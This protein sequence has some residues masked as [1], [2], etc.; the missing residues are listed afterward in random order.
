MMRII[1]PFYALLP[2]THG[3]IPQIYLQTS[4]STSIVPELANR[5]ATRPVSHP[6]LCVPTLNCSTYVGHTAVRKNSTVIGR[7]PRHVMKP[8]WAT[9]LVLVMVCIVAIL[10]RAGQIMSHATLLP[11]IGYKFCASYWS[12]GTAYVQRAQSERCGRGPNPPE[13]RQGQRKPRQAL[14]TITVITSQ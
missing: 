5:E 2:Y 10:R 14:H 3:T 12:S 1:L 9:S 8:R 13:E 11:H 6:W 4:L 7:A